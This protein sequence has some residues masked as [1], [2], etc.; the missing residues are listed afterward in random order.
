MSVLDDTAIGWLRQPREFG[1][2]GDEM[3]RRHL[4]S[5]VH[6]DCGAMSGVKMGGKGAGGKLVSEEREYNYQN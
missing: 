6:R 5:L 2:A 3:R 4:W 1:E